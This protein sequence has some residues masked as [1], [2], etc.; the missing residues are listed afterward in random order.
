VHKSVASKYCKSGNIA[1]AQNEAED[2]D[3]IGSGRELRATS[4]TFDSDEWKLSREVEAV[5]KQASETTTLIEGGEGTR[6]K[7]D[8]RSNRHCPSQIAQEPDKRQVFRSSTQ[9]RW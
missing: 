8:T 9:A 5:L 3:L 4:F 1:T 7:A 2:D 6:G